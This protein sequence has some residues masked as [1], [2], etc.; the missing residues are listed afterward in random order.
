[1]IASL[2]LLS[3]PCF[4]FSYWLSWVPR[5][6]WSYCFQG[7]ERTSYQRTDIIVIYKDLVKTETTKYLTLNRETKDV[8]ERGLPRGE[9]SVGFSDEWRSWRRTSTEDIQ[10]RWLNTFLT[11]ACLCWIDNEWLFTVYNTHFK[12]ALIYLHHI[13]QCWLFLFISY[14]CILLLWNDIQILNK[15][16]SGSR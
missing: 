10:G 14:H 12:K 1:M 15:P 9:P 16:L 8:Y 7:V 2:L 6:S 13:T 5:I 3:S 11:N 4:L